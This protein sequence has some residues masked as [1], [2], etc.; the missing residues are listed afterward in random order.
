MRKYLSILFIL[1]AGL[2][3]GKELDEITAYVNDEII[4]KSDVD[5]IVGP[6]YAKY[7]NSLSEIE[8]QEK[9]KKARLDA[10]QQLID[11]K[12]VLQEARKKE[13]KVNEE[14]L[15]KRFN[16]LKSKFS[17]TKEFE[18]ALKKDSMSVYELKEN[19]KEQLMIQEI[20]K[21]EVASN[22]AVSPKEIEE[23]YESHL[24]EFGEPEKVM[25]SHIL[26][27][28]KEGVEVQE[29]IQ[30]VYMEVKKNADFAALAR[31]H[32]EGPNADKGGDLGFIIRGQMLKGIEDAA[33]SLGAGEVS[34]IIETDIGYHIIKV[35]A[36]KEAR[37]KPIIEVWTDIKNKIF[38]EKAINAHG[39]WIKKLR[40]KAYIV[41]L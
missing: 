5:F 31:Q 1:Y 28:K 30:A 27:K 8:T 20:S 11:R 32:S 36:K 18:E 19:I 3:F 33:F 25:I 14:D 39:E 37:V 7:K 23:Y 4:T 17:S 9:L 15:E 12:L 26:I 16:E 41:V 40:S 2:V 35:H 10:L 6:L 22:V 34:G 21:K 38:Q 29:K 13:I 24:S